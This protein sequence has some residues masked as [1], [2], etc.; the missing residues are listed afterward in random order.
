[1]VHVCRLLAGCESVVSHLDSGRVV[2][3]HRQTNSLQEV[4]VH[5]DSTASLEPLPKSPSHF[6][7]RTI[8]SSEASRTLQDIVMEAEVVVG[9]TG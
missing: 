5:V 2:N 7:S 9:N 1:M 6:H 3:G 8:S 4:D